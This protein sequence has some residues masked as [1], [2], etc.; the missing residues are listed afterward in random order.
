MIPRTPC[1]CLA[2][3]LTACGGSS[4]RPSSGDEDGGTDAAPTGQDGGSD[5]D[6]E[7]DVAPDGG[8]DDVAPDYARLFPEDRVLDIDLTLADE[9][10]ATLMENPTED[11]YVP[12]TLTYDGIVVPDV[13]VRLKGNSSRFS[14]QRQGSERYSF[15]V[16][17]DRNVTGQ[18][19]LGIDKLNLNNGFKDPSFMRERLASEVY[20]ALDVPTIRT[21]HARLSRNGAYFGLYTVVEQVDRDFLREHFPD[22]TGDLYKPEPPAGDLSWHGDSLDGYVSMGLETNEDAPDH[23]SLIRF[24]DVLNNTPDGELEAALP[25]VL[26]VDGTLR[27]LAVTV[28]LVNLDSYLGMGHNYYLYEDRTTGRFVVVPWDLNEAY[29]NFR[30]RFEEDELVNLPYAEPTCDDPNRRPLVTRIL[31]VPAWRAVL[32]ANLEELLTGAWSPDRVS[33]RVHAVADLIRDDVIADPTAF[34]TPQD[35]EAS[36][37]E[38][39]RG[40]F[41]LTS[42]AERRAAALLEQLP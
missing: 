6:A 25:E 42:F 1:A 17:I 31:R 37:D 33:E 34:F 13:A 3:L 20:G 10:W 12:A 19:L 18:E 21:A 28:A 4:N 39:A 29:G 5:P 9:D 27:Y 35:F 40:T 16:D 8:D 22:D 38:G 23:G 14:T 32:E 24:L 41:G 7:A 15:K 26:D 36:L 11:V 30:C 2:L